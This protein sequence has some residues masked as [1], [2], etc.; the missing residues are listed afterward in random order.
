MWSLVAVAAATST[1]AAAA[2]AA[3]L[4]TDDIIGLDGVTAKASFG[5]NQ[6][7]SVN[8]SLPCGPSCPDPASACVPGSGPQCTPSKL[9]MCTAEDN[10]Y[11]LTVPFHVV[12]WDSGGVVGGS[13]FTIPPREDGIYGVQCA[14]QGQCVGFSARRNGL[15]LDPFAGDPFTYVGIPI[16]S[17][18][19]RVVLGPYMEQFV[20]GDYVELVATAFTDGTP[21]CPQLDGL[22]GGDP[23]INASTSCWIYKL[24]GTKHSRS[25]P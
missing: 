10:A 19:S 3:E 25:P 2:A 15:S 16:L 7:F 4:K 24:I 14:L 5:V 6:S 9:P 13:R 8:C 17:P 22:L 18:S 20:A 23:V 1:I 21:V 12:A 11:R